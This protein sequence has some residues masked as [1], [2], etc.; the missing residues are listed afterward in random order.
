MAARVKTLSKGY[1]MHC[2][3]KSVAV[4]AFIAAFGLAHLSQAAKVPAR[5]PAK[6]AAASPSA[7]NLSSSDPAVVD[8]TAAQLRAQGPQGLAAALAYRDNAKLATADLAKLDAAIDKISG[9][10]FGSVSR[11]YWYTD[12]AQA[13]T[14]SKTTGKPILSL[15]LLGNLT[16]DLSCA[17][18]RFF[19]VTLY[20]NQEISAYL[21]EHFILHWQS[22]RPAPKITIDFGDGHVIERTITG[23]SIHY[24]LSSAGQ[25]LDGLPGL[26][27]P[28]AFLAWLKRANDLAA[29]YAAANSGQK[30]FILARYH[31]QEDQRI[32]TE[33][34]KDIRTAGV[35]PSELP[36]VAKVEIPSVA[37]QAMGQVASASSF[38]GP[39]ASYAPPASDSAGRAASK[40]FV[41]RPALARLEIGQPKSEL[42]NVALMEKTAEEQNAAW[43]KIAALHPVTLD[44]AS[45]ALI[46]SQHPEATATANASA[47]PE[48]AF[49]AMMDNFKAAI[50]LDSVRNEYLMHKQIHQWLAQSPRRPP[51]LEALNQRVY[52]ELFMTP[53][54]DPW[55]GLSPVDVYSGLPE[56]GLVK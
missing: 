17:N 44:D 27:A 55:L 4:L 34:D 13:E 46:R 47:N 36:T 6:A 26:Y 56:N 8:A 39:P 30:S 3:L 2:R 1:A 18:S 33:L 10:R 21:R 28:D 15:R 38:G 43:K 42:P 5:R 51:T 14:A 16:D 9:Q 35:L 49:M 12:L 25:P 22:E 32:A 53:R 19:R 50:A 24:L 29:E 54:S 41:E 52:T 48:E 45:L 23:N 40:S 37:K 20:A 11:L 7:A 31:V